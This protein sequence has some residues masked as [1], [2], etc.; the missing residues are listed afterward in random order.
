MKKRNKFLGA[1]GEVRIPFFIW[2]FV[3]P[4]DRSGAR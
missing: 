3:L 1:R 4:F 2:I